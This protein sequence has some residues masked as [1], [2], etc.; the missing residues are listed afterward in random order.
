[1]WKRSGLQHSCRPDN[2]KC[3]PQFSKNN[4]TYKN[5][6]EYIH[7]NFIHKWAVISVI[8]AWRTRMHSSRMRTVHCSN[9]LLGGVCPGVGGV[10]LGRGVSAQRGCLPRRAVCPEGLS[11]QRGVCLGRGVSAWGGVVCLGGVWPGGSAQGSVCPGVSAWGAGCLPGVV[12]L[13]KGAVCPS[14]CWDTPPP[15]TEFLT[16]VRENITFQQL[17]LRTVKIV[18]VS[19]INWQHQ[20]DH[21]VVSTSFVESHRALNGVFMDKSLTT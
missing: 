16:H 4:W 19:D 14:A 1:M 17:R 3:L 6:T 18:A 15:W 7:C 2:I 11:A 12:S 10:C 13:G 20:N 9:H 21:K 8:I 5:S